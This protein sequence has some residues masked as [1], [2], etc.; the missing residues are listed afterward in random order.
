MR[1]LAGSNRAIGLLPGPEDRCRRFFKAGPFSLLSGQVL[2][3]R[4]P[5]HG[6][7]EALAEL[8]LPSIWC[9]INHLDC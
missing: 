3:T 7:C 6:C 4:S 8:E 5:A 9:Y 1:R 2:P